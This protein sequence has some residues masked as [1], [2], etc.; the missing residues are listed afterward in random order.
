V[1]INRK[2]TCAGPMERVGK[3]SAERR[4]SHE[5]TTHT[6]ARHARRR[7]QSV[8]DPHY[9]DRLFFISYSHIFCFVCF[10]HVGRDSVEHEIDDREVVD[11]DQSQRIHKESTRTFVF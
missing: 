11:T 7:E 1:T 4:H 9:V 3:D 10:L 6:S 5:W 2:R 8:S